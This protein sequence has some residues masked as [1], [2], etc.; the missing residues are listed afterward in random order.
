MR[1]AHL[2]DLHLLSL[3]GV[4]WLDFANKRALGGLNL[5]R[6]RARHHHN[7]IFEAMV[8]D[9]N[10]QGIDHVVCTGDLTNLALEPEFRLARDCFERLS[11]EPDQVTVLPGNHDAYVPAGGPCFD[12]VF[13]DY[14]RADDDWRDDGPSP[15]PVVRVRGSAG[16]GPSVAIVALCTA[17]P[18]PWFTAYGTLASDQLTRLA[19]ILAS[20]RLSGSLRLVAIHHPPAGPA[21]TS[22]IRGLHGA[23]ALAEVLARTGAEL[24][25]HGHEHRDMHHQLP[26]PD[27]A[28]IP[29]RGIQSGTYLGDRPER[30]ARYRIFD[31]AAPG[32][33]EARPRV[34][35][36]R[37]RRWDPAAARFVDDLTQPVQEARATGPIPTS[38]PPS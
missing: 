34:H 17:V 26:G 20:P 19:E 7:H 32:A 31:I 12:Q 2:S 16:P 14:Y 1:I 18:T 24:V 22:R 33:L 9:I 15:W 37:L 11:L 38:P 36:H 27:G 28:A 25:L 30:T 6:S 5:L 35:A 29:V 8:E 3:E 21:A 10:A 4:R 13:A 23:A